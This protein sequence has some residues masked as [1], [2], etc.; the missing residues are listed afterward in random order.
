MNTGSAMAAFERMEEKVLELEA[1]SQAAVELG[2]ADL[3]SQ[4]YALEA[5]SNVD[6]ELASLKAQMLGGSSTPAA[7]L[8]AA[9]SSNVDDE[10][11][12]LRAEIDRL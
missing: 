5:G 10:L 2:G 1:R 8:P 12:Q 9:S 3:E 7:S 4:F 6:D 11:A